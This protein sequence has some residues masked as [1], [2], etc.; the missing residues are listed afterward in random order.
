MF[1]FS[2]RVFHFELLKRKESLLEK[3]NHE[4]TPLP[5]QNRSKDIEGK[6]KERSRIEILLLVLRERKGC[7]RTKKK[8]AAN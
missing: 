3:K 7:I 4:T 5:L 1:V 6:G 8:R 2:A